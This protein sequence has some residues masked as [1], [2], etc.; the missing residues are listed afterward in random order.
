MPERVSDEAFE[1]LEALAARFYPGQFVF[2]DEAVD[3]LMG[4]PGLRASLVTSDSP[5]L[6]PEVVRTVAMVAFRSLA[7]RGLPE[8]WKQVL[9]SSKGRP[10][11]VDLYVPRNDVPGV[12]GAVRQL[13]C[14]SSVTPLPQDT[15]R[16]LV[17]RSVGISVR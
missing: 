16:S 6:R 17:A 10:W 7:G 12:R 9:L 11:R 13:G 8:S 5:G 14:S 4:K 1:N 3:D 2:I 15:R